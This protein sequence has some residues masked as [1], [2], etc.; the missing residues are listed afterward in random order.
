MP[1]PGSL[2]ERERE[3]ASLQSL[4][5]AVSAG[6]GRVALIEG[7]AG[8]GKSRLLSELRE[9]ASVEGLRVLAA[10]GSELEREFPYGVVR[11]LFEPLLHGGSNGDG[12]LLAGAAG[13][14][15]AVFEGLDGGQ[16]DTGDASFAALHGLYWLSVNLAGAS[17]TVLAI[18]DLHWC[19]RASLRFVA[20]LMHRLEGLPML[21]A[22]SLRSGD[23]GTDEALVAD[24]SADPA[25]VAVQPGALSREGVGHL[26]ADLLG[27]QPDEGF[28]DACHEATGGNPLLLR[29]LLSSLH[30]EGV[31]PQA[32][33]EQRVR[34]LG[35]RAVSRIVLVRLAR[36][37]QQAIDVARAV[38]VL[39]DSADLPSVAPLAQVDE[40][41]A[42]EAMAVLARA[43][44]LRP[45][46]PL[47]FVHP[48][49]REAVYR[50][51]PAGERELQHAKAA[52]ILRDAGAPAEQIAAHLLVAPRR[53]EEANV[54]LLMEAGRAAL[55]KGAPESAVSYLER[56]LEEPPPPER[57]APL[58][59]ELGLAELRRSVVAA[60]GHLR[61]AH[62]E[63]GDPTLRGIAAY[64]LAHT[65]LFGASAAEARALARQTISE[66]PPDE[67]DMRRRLEALELMTIHFGEEPEP[68]W[69]LEALRD[70][71]PE[72]GGLGAS[73]LTA[74]AAYEWSNAGGPADA[75]VELSM[76]ALADGSLIDEDDGLFYVAAVHPLVIADRPEALEAW[77]ALLARAHV[78]GSLFTVLTAHLFRGYTLLL[79]GELVEAEES[80]ALAIEEGELWGGLSLAALGYS[81]GWHA[82]ALLELGQ[83]EA[84][85]RVLDG[86]P[87]PAGHADGANFVRRGRIKLCLAEG[88]NE[89]A[90]DLAD[91]YARE[92]KLVENP[93]IGPWRSL[94]AEAL[95][96]LGRTGEA[97]ELV[98]EELVLARHWGAPSTV[99]RTLRVLGALE[100]DAGIDRLREAVDVLAAS[101]AKLELAKAHAALGGALRRA[102]KPTDAREPLRHA[103]ELA[104]VCGAVV[105]MADVRA[106]LKAAGVRPRT[107]ALSGLESLTASEQRVAQ[108]AAEGRTNGEVAQTLF[109]TPKTV[110]VHLT[111]VYRKLGISSR[112][113]LPDALQAH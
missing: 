54:D 73:R 16:P 23:P 21:V 75:C 69:A 38:A 104:E 43:E 20:Y 35:P 13:A 92:L 103:L 86:M 105:L 37:P 90:L 58:R 88:R 14:A 71:P 45:D 10:R 109:V 39:G 46:P 56:A 5:G 62:Q 59:L 87:R 91:E 22:A 42:A 96:R 108:L 83:I 18:D 17:P 52:V 9:Q 24:I 74:L 63:L 66:L 36:L 34:D 61:A 97:I 1:E 19:D 25:T 26:V 110:E 93:A 81:L 72:G 11:Q 99:G 48:L 79:H 112:K 57:R 30:A 98:E 6:A 94:K 89:D 32:V 100:R 107:T 40:S 53:G 8:I 70:E 3:L 64:A 33:N 12:D 2:L 49:V 82:E 51:L 27:A 76:R 29:Q 4:I 41:A 68:G 60:A 78:K 55:H 113:R 101:P 47:G 65:L 7:G 50:E 95:D 80:V 28:V 84:A 106:E 102:R 67:V 85:R 15:R 77:D 44:I 111:N 31:T